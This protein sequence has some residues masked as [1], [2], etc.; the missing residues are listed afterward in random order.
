MPIEWN[1]GIALGIDV[2]DQEHMALVSLMNQVSEMLEGSAEFESLAKVIQQLEEYCDLHFAHEEDLMRKAN[3]DGLA[4]HI[5]SHRRFTTQVNEFSQQFKESAHNVD[6]Q[7]LHFL[8]EDWLVNHIQKTDR[9]YLPAVKPYIKAHGP[10]L[11]G[12]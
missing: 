1:D 8:I 5:T 7:A 2:I 6:L 4:A 11:A 10:K 3:Y 12:L 9:D